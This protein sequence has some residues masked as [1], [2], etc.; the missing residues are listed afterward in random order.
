MWLLISFIFGLGCVA[1]FVRVL[2][3]GYFVINPQERV[4]QDAL[5]ELW[6]ESNA[7]GL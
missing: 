6:E 4:M 3:A 5:D 2:V 1:M 7:A